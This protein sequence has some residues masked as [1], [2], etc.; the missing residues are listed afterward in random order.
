M[1]A[2]GNHAEFIL[3]AYIGVALVI[4]LLIGNTLARRRS[5]EK[6]IARLEASLPNRRPVDPR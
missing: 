5:V 3:W 1:I 4:G 6:R 2:L